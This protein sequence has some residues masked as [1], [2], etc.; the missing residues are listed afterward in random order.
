MTIGFALHELVRIS[1]STRVS[2][3]LRT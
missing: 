1:K 3:L 2:G